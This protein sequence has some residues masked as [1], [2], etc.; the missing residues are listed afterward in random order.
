MNLLEIDAVSYATHVGQQATSEIARLLWSAADAPSLPILNWYAVGPADKAD[1]LDELALTEG[2][3]G[4]VRTLLLEQALEELG[5]EICRQGISQGEWLWRE[6]R[7][8][9]IG[10]AEP[11]WS[12]MPPEQRL[13]WETFVNITRQA[14]GQIR[15]QQLA[16]EDVMRPAPGSVPVSLKREDSIFEEEDGLG[17]MRPEAVAALRNSASY[18]QAAQEARE[19]RAA[20]QAKFNGADPAKFDHDGNGRP[21]GAA[22]PAAAPG[23]SQSAV[24]K[25]IARNQ[26]KASKPSPLSVGEAPAKP[27]VNRGGRGRKKPS[28]AK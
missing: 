24:E 22:P 25:S 21:G 3:E 1:W 13:A 20:D 8:R 11:D 9:D 27:P 14:F 12:D 26:R 6:A 17:D 15:T 19:T 10:N 5:A 28:D 7:E 4:E 2:E 23:Q 16:L 18:T